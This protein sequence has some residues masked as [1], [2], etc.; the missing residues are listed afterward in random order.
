MD[1][2]GRTGLAEYWHYSFYR[3]CLYNAGYSFLGK[4]LPQATLLSGATDVRYTNPLAGATLSLPSGTTQEL[5]NVLD[6]NFD[7]RLLRSSFLVGTSTIVFDTYTTHEYIHSL[8]DVPM[9]L[10]HLPTTGGS[11]FESK[12]RTNLLGTPYL[13]VEQ[14]DGYCGGIVVTPVEKI[15]HLYA[16]CSERKL[17]NQILDSLT[18][19]DNA[20]SIY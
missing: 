20:V 8:A 11:I 1:E 13:W 14:N 7:Y 3:N 17:I 9:Y 15:L 2:A 4:P 19:T 5:D 10:D 6:V 18:I 12:E 16:P